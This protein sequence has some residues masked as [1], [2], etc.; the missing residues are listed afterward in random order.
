MN[1]IPKHGER[2]LIVGRSGSGK[3]TFAKWML[4]HMPGAI[5][6]DTKTEPAFDDMG[7]VVATTEQAFKVFAEEGDE[8]DYVIVR[9][10]PGLIAY[11]MALD[12]MLLD[13]YD[14]GHGITAYIDEGYQF[15]KNGR[16]GPGYLSLLTRGRSREITTITSS[17]RPAFL[18]LFAFTELNHLYAFRLQ[19]DDDR[20]RL[21]NVISGYAKRPKP[22]IHHF[23]YA[24]ADE[25]TI[26][27][28]PPI[29]IDYRPATL[30]R[31]NNAGDAMPSRSE[32][33][34]WI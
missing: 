1:V 2:A 22:P 28:F 18:S 7:P 21:G 32:Y 13:H 24:L 8:V 30:Y 11:P 12:Q 27:R 16:P 3:T 10:D 4:W 9:P 6:Y 25:E 20:A 33:F 5:I 17:Q 34:N 15:H 31:E 29:D 26:T 14:Y 23:D 19:H